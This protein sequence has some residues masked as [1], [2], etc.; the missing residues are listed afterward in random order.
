MFG[1][2]H[3]LIFV[4]ISIFGILTAVTNENGRHTCG[5]PGPSVFANAF[6]NSSTTVVAD[7]EQGFCAVSLVAGV[8]A[9]LVSGMFFLPH[10]ILFYHLLFIPPPPPSNVNNKS[11]CGGGQRGFRLVKPTPIVFT[12]IYICTSTPPPP[13]FKYLI[14]CTCP[15]PPRHRRSK[16]TPTTMETK[17]KTI[18]AL[19]LNCVWRL[20]NARGSFDSIRIC[21]HRLQ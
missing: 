19:S 13:F 14:V 6:G 1:W 10:S 11:L 2:L 12:L 21:K 15:L 5:P 17:A 7:V 9:E 4:C 16:R 3:T 18:T 20:R 8:Q